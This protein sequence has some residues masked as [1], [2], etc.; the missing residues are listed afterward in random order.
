MSL[1]WNPSKRAGLLLLKLGRVCL[2]IIIKVGGAKITMRLFI[3]FTV[4]LLSCLAEDD[5]GQGPAVTLVVVGANGDLA[6]KKIWPS[7]QEMIFRNLTDSS[8][9]HV[10][11]GT[12]EPVEITN[13]VFT[14]Y[15][16]NLTCHETW[17]ISDRGCSQLNRELAQLVIPIQ[18]KIEEDYSKL[19]HIIETRMSKEN[20]TESVRIFYLSVPPFAYNTIS[21]YINS[22]ARPSLPTKLRVAIEKPFGKDLPSAKDLASS[23]LSS[24]K[25]DEV[26]LV[27]HYLHKPGVAQI[28]DFRLANIGALESVWNSESINHIEVVVRESLDVRGRTG[29]YDQYG[30]VRD[31]LQNHLTELVTLL[32]VDLRNT[33]TNRHFDLNSAKLDVLKAIYSPFYDSA[34]LG[35]YSGYQDHVIL[36]TPTTTNKSNTAT[37]AAVLIHI[38]SPLWVGV[39]IIVMSGKKLSKR[40]AFVR[41]AFKKSPNLSLE[42]GSTCNRDIVFKIEEGNDSIIIVPYRHD[43]SVPDTW[44][45]S[46]VY[47]NEGGHNCLR[48]ELRLSSSLGRLRQAYSSV[49]MSLI[50]GQ[51]DLFVPLR[52][53]LESWRVWSP[54][55]IESDQYEGRN[56]LVYTDNLLDKV[57]F[58]VNGSRLIMRSIV[59]SNDN[60]F[61]TEN[62][63]NF[64]SNHFTFKSADKT[65]VLSVFGHTIHN[66]PRSSLS[67]EIVNH[68]FLS[69]LSSIEERNHFHIAFPGGNSPLNIYQSLVLN[70]RYELP[71]KRTHVWQTDERCV[72]V[73]SIN[74]NMYQLSNHLLEYVSVPYSNIHPLY[75]ICQSEVQ[76]IVDQYGYSLLEYF[77][78]VLL[79][80]GKD[81]HI[82]SLFSDG[83]RG[84]NETFQF[85]S[86]PLNY[87]INVKERVTLTLQRLVKARRI[88]V[89]VT[90][91]GKCH[92]VKL[93]ESKDRE[94]S[95]L[96]FIQLL[97][98]A[99][100]GRVNVWIDTDVCN[101]T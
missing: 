93:I 94:N 16:N 38:Q 59:D 42:N 71:W 20:V 53:V 5:S 41:V 14:E 69:A 54:L 31:M 75:P 92:L 79:G 26:F 30:V 49:L 18:L 36:D 8:S 99:V 83:L 25:E 98:Q 6:K 45:T 40:E 57:T 72:P 58:K 78:Y 23:I 22:F 44:N 52:N 65:S 4:L 28:L 80:V 76:P 87:P 3:I 74:S 61:V 21:R 64:E 9:L 82:A 29:Y 7:L 47:N 85:V 43:Y 19:K 68:M 50:E 70:Y 86:L 90:G 89:I 24:L 67:H 32:T 91:D 77:D 37:F 13:Q 81:G 101:D 39:P 27:D 12:R 73:T 35:Q 2:F 84:S 66:L 10:Y 63:L 33:S 34:I 46:S 88:S 95:T 100:P 60:H 56:L 55:L 48:T 15:F 62:S 11:A 1:C 17:S 96:P 51:S 97:R